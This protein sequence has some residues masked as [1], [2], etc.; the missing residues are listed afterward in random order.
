V[1]LPLV[2]QAKTGLSSSIVQYIISHYF[3]NRLRNSDSVKVFT[4]SS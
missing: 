4:P 1:R 2:G 3:C